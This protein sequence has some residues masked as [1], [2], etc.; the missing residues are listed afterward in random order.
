MTEEERPTDPPPSDDDPNEWGLKPIR[1]SDLPPS[2][3]DGPS[4][5][6]GLKPIQWEELEPV[7]RAL[8]VGWPGV[9]ARIVGGI[10]KPATLRDLREAAR[11]QGY[12]LVRETEPA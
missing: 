3:D 2:A 8:F 10:L 5:W 4:E 6:E 12:R 9:E 7:R 11:A 1:P